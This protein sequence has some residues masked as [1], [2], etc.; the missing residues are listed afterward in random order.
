M[1]GRYKRLT[2]FIQEIIHHLRQ[3]DLR[4]D[5]LPSGLPEWR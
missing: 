2:P 4:T 3:F 5:L 1:S